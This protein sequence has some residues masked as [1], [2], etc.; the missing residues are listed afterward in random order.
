MKQVNIH[1]AKSHLSDLI[2]KAL[3]GEEI[4]IAKDHVPV[5]KLVPVQ[6]LQKGRKIGLAKNLISI[7]PDFDEPLDDFKDYY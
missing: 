6:P 1:I 2:K 4:I 7:S 3:L 5:V